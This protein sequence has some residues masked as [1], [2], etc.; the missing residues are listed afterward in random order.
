MMNLDQKFNGDFRDAHVVWHDDKFNFR[1][2]ID[3]GMLVEGSFDKKTGILTSFIV[4][5]NIAIADIRVK[6]YFDPFDKIATIMKVKAFY[7]ELEDISLGDYFVKLIGHV[8]SV[9]MGPGWKTRSYSEEVSDDIMISIIQQNTKVIHAMTEGNR[10][11]NDASKE[12]ITNF[13]NNILNDMLNT[14]I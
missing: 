8:M 5:D 12:I 3:R 9:Y 7:W 11:N 14:P 6:F 1:N 13:V 10:W 2:G 4:E